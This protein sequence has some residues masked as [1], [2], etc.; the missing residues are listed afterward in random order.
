MLTVLWGS[1]AGITGVGSV[2]IADPAG[3]S[4]DL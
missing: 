4:H 2:Q 1:A 3:S